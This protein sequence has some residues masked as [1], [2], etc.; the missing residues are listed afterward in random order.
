M[1]TR[2]SIVAF[3]IAS[4]SVA[5]PGIQVSSSA[6]DITYDVVIYG[7]TSAG[8]AAAVQV[9]RM[10]GTVIVIEPTSRIGGLTTG[11][12]GQTDIG[13]KAAI[14]GV[15]REF[16]QRIRKHYD[17]D[18]SWRWQQPDAYRSGG[19]SRS[20]SQ[21]DTMWTFEPSV[22]LRVMQDFVAENEITVVYRQRLDRSGPGVVRDGARILT[23]Q[24]EGG[25]TFRGRTF[26]DATYEGDLL[27]EAEVS[28]TVGR[29]DNGRYGETLSGVQTRR[30]IHHQFV[31]GVDQ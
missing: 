23:I 12:L 13:N 2:G 31:R 10:G 20:R 3:L 27:A 8:I 4:A 26:I 5:C 15:S 24:M 7:G 28:W 19:Q 29:E 18:A 11:G 14:G 21:E 17:A 6:Q 1:M 30:A 22:A 25:R 16:Y 9:K